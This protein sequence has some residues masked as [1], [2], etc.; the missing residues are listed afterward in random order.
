MGYVIVIKEGV[1]RFF[2]SITS[3]GTTDGEEYYVGGCYG[4]PDQNLPDMSPYQFKIGNNLYKMNGPY[5]F[6]SKSDINKSWDYSKNNGQYVISYKGPSVTLPIYG[7]YGIK[8]FTPG[9]K[10]SYK[11]IFTALDG[12][13]K[14]FTVN[15]KVTGNGGVNSISPSD[16]IKTPGFN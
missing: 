14:T 1:Y 2:T 15:F 3:N 16:V 8:G 13:G 12:S 7:D 4:Y 6:V 10:G 5:G 11:C 9:K